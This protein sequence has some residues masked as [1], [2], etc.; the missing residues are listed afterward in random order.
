MTEYNDSL[1][2]R[3]HD[4]LHTAIDNM[5]AAVSNENVLIEVAAQHPLID[6]TTPN[7][8]FMARLD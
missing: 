4:K 5:N 2:N 6:G 1:F 7:N 8:E 3:W